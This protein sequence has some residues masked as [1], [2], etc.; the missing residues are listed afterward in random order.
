MGATQKSIRIQTNIDNPQDQYLT[1][2]FDR[3]IGLIEVL[4]LKIP[5]KQEFRRFDSQ[6]G[7][8]CG[9][10]FANGNSANNSI[11][12]P[13]VKVSIFISKDQNLNLDNLSDINKTKI[14]TAELQYPFENSS[15]KYNGKRFSL[16]PKWS[17]N[18]GISGFIFNVLGIGNTPKQPVGSNRPELEEVLSNEDLSYLEKK[19]YKYSTTT[20]KSGDYMIYLPV[21]VEN[22]EIICEVDISDIGP[23]SIN[24]HQMTQVMGYP[25]EYF[26]NGKL[27]NGVDIDVAPN[28]IRLTSTV[29]V[30]PLWSQNSELANNPETVGITR[31]DF[32]LPVELKANFTIFGTT[33][34]MKRSSWYFDN[35]VFHMFLFFQKLVIANNFDSN[36]T[37]S[38]GYGGCEPTI[39]WLGPNFG[40]CGCSDSSGKSG[41]FILQVGIGF[42]VEPPS[43]DIDFGNFS[44]NFD[45][46]CFKLGFGVRFCIILPSIIPGL[47]IRAFTSRPCVLQGG[48]YDLPGSGV[49]YLGA[50][51]SCKKSPVGD[52]SDD[53]GDLLSNSD[54]IDKSLNR[55]EELIN[56]ENVKTDI[57]LFSVT[58]IKNNRN[59]DSDIEFINE[60]QYVKLIDDGSFLLNINTNKKKMVNSEDGTLVETSDDSSG[61]F[62]EFDGYCIFKPE[63]EL[64]SAPNKQTLTTLKMKVPQ[65]GNDEV[66]I[67]NSF[68][69]FK[70]GEFYS[71]SQ[72]IPNLGI[73]NDCNSLFSFTKVCNDYTNLTGYPHKI[74]T[75]QMSNDG[76]NNM[77]ANEIG[78]D[79]GTDFNN[80]PF[81]VF[82]GDFLNFM[83]YFVNI[84]YRAKY[85]QSSKE[86]SFCSNLV[87]PKSADNDR[88]DINLIPNNNPIGGGLK[89]T[90]YMSNPN[91][92]ITQFIKVD[93][94]D[95][96]RFLERNEKR[97]ETSFFTL[98]EP[99]NYPSNFF[100]KGKFG[101]DSVKNLINKNII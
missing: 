14:K 58:N 72:F 35:I 68:Q 20:N 26:E 63:I 65:N 59:P 54:R 101:V 34:N 69:N 82:R 52:D 29:T 18:R 89:N 78:T 75:P 40:T 73:G 83:L 92:I 76:I 94:T 5:M 11:G 67:Y 25:E 37:L 91:N 9:R 33:L 71:V 62:T 93:K 15:T 48:D 87:K 6:T 85:G 57:Q 10:V 46:G 70:F 1:V 39:N 30:K 43:L 41:A 4:S 88:V 60:S 56:A 24:G 21:G 22:Y 98:K 61:I 2:P 50:L 38:L 19:Y 8:I 47:R 7:I 90:Q 36:N 97:Y 66:N 17:T 16:L 64:G 80:A 42:K 49:F 55:E 45:A 3:S 53:I 44:F 96:V 23:Y 79:F 95:L 31:Q 100:Y 13:N 12:V 27:K 86:L 81:D 32:R 77:T 51:E 28:I 84:G 74:L 99:Q